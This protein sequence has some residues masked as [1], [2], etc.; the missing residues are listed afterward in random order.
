MLH[1][2]NLVSR[3]TA[4]KVKA[5]L[6]DR[7]AEESADSLYY[8]IRPVKLL[9]PF[10]AGQA[11]GELL[12]SSGTA[13]TGGEI[14]LHR[15]DAATGGATGDTVWGIYRGRWEELGAAGGAGAGDVPMHR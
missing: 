1:E 12:D 9:G 11:T 4:E 7:R 10:S 6:N 15:I 8:K 2:K 14:V 13:V 3:E 5:L